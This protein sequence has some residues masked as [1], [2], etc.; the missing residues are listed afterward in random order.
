MFPY[1]SSHSF[2]MNTKFPIVFPS[3]FPS[4]FS[5]SLASAWHL[6]VQQRSAT[7]AHPGGPADGW[8]RTHFARGYPAGGDPLDVENYPLDVGQKHVYSIIY[9]LMII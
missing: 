8:R 5:I 4:V 2:S 1:L 7:G 9:K 6:Q 3:F